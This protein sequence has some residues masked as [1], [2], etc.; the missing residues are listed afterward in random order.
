MERKPALEKI[1]FANL[2]YAFEISRASRWPEKTK[3][4]T[5]YYPYWLCYA[6]GVCLEQGYEV[7]LVDCITRKMSTEDLIELVRT[8]QAD[9][10]MGEITTSTLEHD[11]DTLTRLKAVFPE[12]RI[13]IGGT[14]A[15]VLAE[16]VLEQCPAIDIIVRQEYDYTIGEVIRAWDEPDALSAVEGISFRTKQGLATHGPATHSLATHTPDR[17]W[18]S[19]IDKLPFVSPIYERFLDV[20]DYCY[21]F[22]KKPMIQIFSA[23]GCPFRCNFCSYPQSMSGHRFRKRSVNNFVDELAYIHEHMPYIQEIFIEDDTF[24]V[25]KQRVLDICDEIIARG[26]K[27]VWSCNT[28]ADLPY[29]VMARMKQAG[30]RLLVV[31]YESGNQTVLDETQK[32]I[33]LEDSLAFAHNT[34]KLKLKVFG[35]FMIGLKGDN[36]ETIEET[37]QFAKKTYANEVFF[38]QAVPFPGTAFYDW[39]RDAGYLRTEDYARWLNPDGYLNCL[40]DYPYADHRQIEKLRDHL[41]SRYYFSFTYF[42]KTFLANLTW[43]EFKRVMKAGTTYIWFRIRKLGK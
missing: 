2:P 11:Y 26:L 5:L 14:H 13:V 4:G 40:V 18:L 12:L 38:Q 27:L 16:Q 34:K 43:S 20:N 10:L 17:P 9:Y 42:V 35:C 25:D 23:R 3:S 37:F 19:D 15:T 30:C 1:L 28:R 7:S 39:V 22:A 32:G 24:T 21:A 29:E 8:E 41:M 6:A 31:G 33:T 36:L